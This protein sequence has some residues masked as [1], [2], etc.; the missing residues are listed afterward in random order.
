M[1]LDPTLLRAFVAV[2]Q[3]GGFTRAAQRL[4][5][6]QSAVSHQMRRLEEHVGRPLMHRTTRTLTLTDDGIEFLRHAEQ[7]L[8]SL[9][10]L[11]RRFAPSPVTGVV[12]FGVPD[13]FMGESLA[14]LLCRFAR[15]YPS[16]RLEVSVGMHMD[17]RALIAAGE[18]D[19]AVVIAPPKSARRGKVL[20]RAQ[21]VWVAAD[22]FDATQGAPLPLAFFPTPCI[23]RNLGVAALDGTD[24]AWHVVFTSPSLQG[25]RAAVLAGLAVT[26]LTRDD[27]EPGMTIVDGRYGLPPLAPVDFTLIRGADADTPAAREF[28]QLIVELQAP[29][30]RR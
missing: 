28:A 16:V 22:A 10:A 3:T 21:L 20:R 19:L 6:T 7:V 13:N 26:V 23:Y 18:L 15:A 12:R 4:H 8:G 24:V 1:D 27:I 2:A 25:I 11:S 17:L 9:D 30:R 29:A 5:L 14:P